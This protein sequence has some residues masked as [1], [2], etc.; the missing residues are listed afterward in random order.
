MLGTGERIKEALMDHRII[1][2]S[3]R[4]SQEQL[5]KELEEHLL[6][7]NGRIEKETVSR[8]VR[9]PEATVLVA[10][11]SSATVLLTGV[12][13]LARAHAVN[14]ITLTGKSGWSVKIPADTPVDDIDKFIDKVKEKE[15]EVINI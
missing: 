6:A 14:M 4:L 11:V 10:I 5:K 15:I 7:G 13:A 8:E 2:D 3:T 1:V 9:A 12:L